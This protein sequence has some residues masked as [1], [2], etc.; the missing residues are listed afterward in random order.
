MAVIRPQVDN[1]TKSA[2]RFTASRRR[3]PEKVRSAQKGEKSKTWGVVVICPT[4]CGGPAVHTES[5]FS[6]SAVQHLCPPPPLAERRHSAH[7]S[8]GCRRQSTPHL[9]APHALML[10]PRRG[11]AEGPCARPRVIGS[12][13]RPPCGERQGSRIKSARASKGVKRDRI[14]CPPNFDLTS[15]VSMPLLGYR[16][17]AAGPIPFHAFRRACRYY[18]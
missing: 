3:S 16:R 17:G 11:H 15:S 12:L 13:R 7:K 8:A 4:T 1:R 10:G 2:A 5:L 6:C 18:S 14:R 9:R